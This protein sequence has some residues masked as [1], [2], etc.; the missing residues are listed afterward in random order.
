[1]SQL[2]AEAM[3][4]EFYYTRLGQWTFIHRLDPHGSVESI[5]PGV[6]RDNRPV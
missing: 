3:A 2:K 5:C 4:R 6:F 1:M